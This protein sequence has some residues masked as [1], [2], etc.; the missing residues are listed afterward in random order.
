M[1]VMGVNLFSSLE[2]GAMLVLLL[3]KWSVV[4]EVRKKGWRGVEFQRNF[5]G[6]RTDGWTDRRIG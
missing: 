3:F 1:T 2:E 4:D 5:D 6:R